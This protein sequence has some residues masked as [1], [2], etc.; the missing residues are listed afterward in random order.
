LGR[1][2]GVGSPEAGCQPDAGGLPHKVVLGGGL[3]AVDRVPPRL[4]AA[5]LARTLRLST[6]ARDQSIAAASPNQIEDNLVEPLPHAC[7]LP[8]AQPPS[9]GCAAA[10]S[11]C[12]GHVPPGTP[13]PQD[14]DDATQRGAIRDA[15]TATFGLGR[16]LGQQGFDGLPEVVRNK[17]CRVHGPPSCHLG[18]VLQHGLSL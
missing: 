11:E 16:F 18:S 1:V 9:A 10:A 8:I 6:L 2:V 17:G 3:A 12:I 7:F 13:R 15:G 14:E 5:L 4:L